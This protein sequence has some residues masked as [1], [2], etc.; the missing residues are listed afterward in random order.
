MNKPK[1]SFYTDI[2]EKLLELKTDYP[3]YSMGKHLSTA[4]DEYGDLWGM[5]DKEMA[6]AITRYKAQMEMNV[7]RETDEDMEKIIREG[8]NLKG[9]SSLE[10]D[11]EEY[12]YED[13]I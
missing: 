7:S 12:D 9:L 2:I 1:Q 5:T 11:D 4:L 13:D 6:F 8:I 3:S 10:L